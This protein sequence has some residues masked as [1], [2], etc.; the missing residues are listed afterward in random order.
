[1]NTLTLDPE[2]ARVLA[3]DLN[4]SADATPD[5]EPQ[6]PQPTPGTLEL[7]PAFID[8]A[9]TLNRRRIVLSSHAR[10]LAAAHGAVGGH[11]DTVVAADSALAR[12]FR[13]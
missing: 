11:I 1:M 8:A 7:I 12:G 4:D 9:R 3:R 5:E 13:A 2:H 10:E 6:A